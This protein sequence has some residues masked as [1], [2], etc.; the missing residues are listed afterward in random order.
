M[1]ARDAFGTAKSR[2]G[3]V[4]LKPVKKKKRKRSVG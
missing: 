1:S 2:T 3:K 4:T